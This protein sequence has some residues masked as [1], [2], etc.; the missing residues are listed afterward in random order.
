[1]FDYLTEQRWCFSLS[2]S[3][4]VCDIEMITCCLPFVFVAVPC[5]VFFTFNVSVKV[6]IFPLFINFIYQ[7]KSRTYFGLFD[8]AKGQRVFTFSVTKCSLPKPSEE[9]IPNQPE[10]YRPP[11]E[12][13][14][15][16][17]NV[18]EIY[19]GEKT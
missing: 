10:S 17:T 1:M 14:P 2:G 4:L 12:L 18:G 8:K 19:D 3:V 11:A 9:I 5:L 13:Y 6:I 7:R 15:Y 16:L